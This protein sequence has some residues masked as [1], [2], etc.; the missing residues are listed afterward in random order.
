MPQSRVLEWS[1]GISLDPRR[2]QQ[3]QQGE[4][5]PCASE[6]RYSRAEQ[7]GV[8]ISLEAT[9]A[10]AG[11]GEVAR[12]DVIGQESHSLC[13]GFSFSIASYIS[14]H[15]MLLHYITLLVALHRS[16]DS[17]PLLPFSPFPLL[18]S[19]IQSHHQFRRRLLPAAA[20]ILLV[21]Q[22]VR[23]M[24]PVNLFNRV[25]IVNPSETSDQS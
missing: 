13:V 4:E 12:G 23:R 17:W 16:R 1:V 6:K 22:R 5:R 3:Q 18:L 8:E 7:S 19:P 2:L 14:L 21:F 25:N 20:I 24:T 10:A 9:A 15:Y 11:G